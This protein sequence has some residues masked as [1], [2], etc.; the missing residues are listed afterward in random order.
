M[1][2]SESA[3]SA[4]ADWHWTTSNTPEVA[5][6]APYGDMGTSQRR[7]GDVRT[8]WHV[9]KIGPWRAAGVDVVVGRR[10]DRQMSPVAWWE[11]IPAPPLPLHSAAAGR[12]LREAAE[13]PGQPVL[14][15]VFGAGWWWL[16][17]WVRRMCRW[18]WGGGGRHEC[19]RQHTLHEC[20]VRENQKY[21]CAGRRIPLF[22]HWRRKGRSRVQLGHLSFQVWG[23]C[24]TLLPVSRRTRRS[25]GYEIE[26]QE[27][28]PRGWWRVAL[29]CVVNQWWER[30]S[31]HRPRRLGDSGNHL[32]AGSELCQASGDAAGRD[33]WCFGGWLRCRSR[34]AEALWAMPH[35]EGAGL[36]D[37]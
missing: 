13:E 2:Q 26:R 14:A 32:G 15:G 8:W 35:G 25:Q 19:L 31:H 33:L 17:R 20:G 22:F 36:G 3:Y 16:H 34:A 21:L 27:L 4:I 37:G 1:S 11:W 5:I 24:D 18:M 9:G 28:S 30:I 12:K 6:R 7:N 23:Q 29:Q 10:Q